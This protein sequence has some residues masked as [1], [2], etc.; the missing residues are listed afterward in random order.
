MNRGR[1]SSRGEIGPASLAGLFL[2][3]ALFF[4]SV[5][6]PSAAEKSQ[7]QEKLEQAE[8]KE[9]AILSELETLEREAAG[10]EERLVGLEREISQ[11]SQK[12]NEGAAELKKL[13][14]RQKDRK[15]YLARRLKAVYRLR[16][17][18]ILPILLRAA[19]FSD[20]AQT[21][22]RLSLILAKDE[23][24]LRDIAANQVKIKESQVIIEAEQR[25]LLE[26]RSALD[27]QR[28]KTEEAKR[29]QTSLLIQVHR[30]KE[31]YLALIRSREESRERVLKEVIIKPRE[32][33]EDV[34]PAPPPPARKDEKPAAARVWPDFPGAKGRIPRPTRG[35]VVGNFGKNPGPFNTVT[36]RRGLVFEVAAGEEV[37]AAMSGEVLYIGW[38][39][40]YGNIIILNHGR[41][42]Y[43]LT[44]GLSGI[45][46]KAGDW[47]GSGEILGLAPRSGEAGKKEIYFEIRHGG[48]AL[49]PAGW[50]SAK[51]VA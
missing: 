30:K 3:I 21:Y 37:R 20:L 2:A 6:A 39:K 5:P 24:A 16:D 46:P 27:D 9:L 38:M 29:R 31:L 14:R 36:V 45:R 41:R 26:L 28:A 13:E 8:K 32:K 47:V 51:P 11:S 33:Q 15:K 43:T 48:Q 34:P 22:Q 44:G 50:L 1:G 49:D 18:G 25:R 35:K 42:Y 4:L 23:E 7:E 40:G 12:L 10:L 19:S 17:G